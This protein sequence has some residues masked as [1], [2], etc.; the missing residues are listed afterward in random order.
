MIVN[1]EPFLSVVGAKLVR[2]DD[3]NYLAFSEG[4]AMRART[5]FTRAAPDPQQIVANAAERAI[6]TVVGRLVRGL[7]P[8]IL[9]ADVVYRGKRTPEPFYLELDAVAPTPTG[10]AILEVKM[11]RTKLRSTARKQLERVAKIAGND[12]GPLHLVA[13]IVLPLKY[14]LDCEMSEWTRIT[15]GDLRSEDLPLRSMLYVDIDD[16]VALFDEKARAALAEV[17]RMELIRQEAGELASAGDLD[18]ARDLRA[19]I[20]TA[21]REAGTLSVDDDGMRVEGGEAAG[22]LARKL[23]NLD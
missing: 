21:P 18:A 4:H 6:R 11:G 1:D 3:P 14:P 9:Q 12:L 22:W 8:R 15:V 13:V 7:S 20:T 10:L 2:A 5:R 16:L 19:S 23:P 17:R